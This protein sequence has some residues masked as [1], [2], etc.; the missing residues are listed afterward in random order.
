MPNATPFNTCFCGPDGLDLGIKLLE[1][2][3]LL[4]TYP[5]L[6]DQLKTTDVVV[7]GQNTCGQLGSG[8]TT[9]ASN[10]SVA[11]HVQG[12]SWKDIKLS[13]G[14][15]LSGGGGF[16]GGIKQDG[17]LWMWG[18][19][20]DGRLGNNSAVKQSSPVQTISTGTN[21][22]SLSLG[23]AHV[24]AIK[25]DGTLW[26]WG[27][28]A[29]GQLGDGTTTNRSS[30]VQTISTGTNWKLV[31]VGG[32]FNT[33][34]SAGIK[35]DG[36]LWMWGAN[37][38]FSG[39]GGRLGD[40]TT[41]ARC[42]PVQTSTGGSNWRDISLGFYHAAA[43]KTDGTLWLWGSNRSRQIQPSSSGTGRDP[44]QATIGG[45]PARW[46]QIATQ[47]GG[48]LALGCDG[49]LWSW[50]FNGFGT[51]PSGTCFG[52]DPY[53]P[54]F[55]YI[56][57]CCQPT[58][59]SQGSKRDWKCIFEFS[60][61]ALKQ[62]GSLWCWYKGTTAGLV[63]GRSSNN[64]CPVT[65]CTGK[66]WIKGV[67]SGTFYTTQNSEGST[68]DTSFSVILIKDDAL[69]C[70]DISGFK[71]TH[72][73]LGTVDFDDVY[74]RKC[75][76]NEG[77]LWMAGCNQAGALGD[78]T[79]IN[80]C[81]PTQIWGT[82]WKT[83]AAG[84]QQFFAGIKQDGTL[85]TW[86]CNLRGQLGDGTTINKSSPIQTL[87][88]G[89]NWKSISATRNSV[90]AIKSDGTLWLWGYGGNGQLG[91]N[92][93]T[94]KCSPVQT[95]SQGTNWRQV[96]M[97]DGFGGAIK[98]DGTL[99]TWGY[100]RCGALGDG[101]LTCRSSPV[102]TISGGT[103]WKQVSAEISVNMGAIKTDGTLWMWG[104]NDGGSV[105]ANDSGILRYCSPVQTIAGG[106]NWICVSVGGSNSG[107][108]KTDGTLWLWGGNLSGEVG[109]TTKISRS[110]PV[111]TISGGNNWKYLS[112]G[113]NTVG[114]IKGDGSLW[115]WGSN[116]GGQFGTGTVVSACS[117]VQFGKPTTWKQVAIF[118]NGLGALRHG[119]ELVA[120]APGGG[121]GGGGT[122][123]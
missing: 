92:T 16:A 91:D 13:K 88:G 50:G 68:G 122:G 10:H 83:I 28:N 12:P 109:D 4:E 46:T 86:G 48:T 25:T 108:L 53:N 96:T 107:G 90:A 71:F 119:D 76:F 93:T 29:C 43:I 36:T 74:V 67:A 41:I 40:G 56:T 113:S 102:Q 80:K 82:N 106:S 101:T 121:G 38:N 69:L 27:C 78:G 11:T 54:G 118:A 105:G 72:S 34:H 37:D 30:P 114:A 21:W 66:S 26:T 111:Q 49:S 51:L 31:N 81:S 32:F 70:C 115:A 87:S 44:T 64:A 24:A 77:E 104:W 116:Q 19:A 15:V 2:D 20:S 7:W 22:K 99:W 123:L 55:G 35:T 8:T 103:N 42:S 84:G 9:N 3:Q 14:D 97:G 17:T 65:M 112:V 95:L 110:S 120:A 58:L 5:G 98:T 75:C 57:W 100:N 47:A 79:T 94:N 89:T 60:N 52:W 61:F 23:N 18:Y 117:P 39:N 62:D 85:W 73:T 6:V 45:G 63:P 1:K 59:E 33:G